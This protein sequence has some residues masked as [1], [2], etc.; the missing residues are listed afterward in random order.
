MTG[1]MSH[2]SDAELAGGGVIRENGKYIARD[3]AGWKTPDAGAATSV[4]CAVSPMSQSS[5]YCENGCLER[6][7]RQAVCPKDMSIHLAL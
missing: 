7:L 6:A 5:Q 4:W 3:P 2:L 1:L